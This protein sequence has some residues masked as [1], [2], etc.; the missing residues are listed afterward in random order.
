V[1]PFKE[2]KNRREGSWGEVQLH[3]KTKFR[4]RTC[5]RVDGG[6]YMEKDFF[7]LGLFVAASSLKSDRGE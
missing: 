2:K 7:V 3:I 6:S 1:G 5:K 4:S